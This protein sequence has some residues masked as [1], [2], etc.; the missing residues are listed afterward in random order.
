MVL[1]PRLDVLI[2]IENNAICIVLTRSQWILDITR[3]L[4]S[5]IVT[6]MASPFGITMA[7]KVT[8]DGPKSIGN[9]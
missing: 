5:F 3:D 9:S 1:E 4:K 2:G 6:L 7:F 8:C